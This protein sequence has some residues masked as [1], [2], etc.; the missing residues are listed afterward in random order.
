MSNQEVEKKE[1]QHVPRKRLLSAVASIMSPCNNANLD[2]PFPARSFSELS[3][4]PKQVLMDIA[5]MAPRPYP[6]EAL[7][8]RV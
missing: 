3:P 7:S 2:L 6:H 1:A 5:I 8:A 4:K